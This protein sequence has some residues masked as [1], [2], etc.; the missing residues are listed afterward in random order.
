MQLLSIRVDLMRNCQ[1]D[2]A[3]RF[4]RF[5]TIVGTAYLFVRIGM[6]LLA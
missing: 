2:L 4:A 5:I 6:G 3:D 1:V